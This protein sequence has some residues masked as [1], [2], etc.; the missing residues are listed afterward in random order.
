MT[1]ETA[2]RVGMAAGHLFTRGDHRH[3]AVIGKDTRLSGYLLEPALTAGL[4]ATGMDIIL[5]G[6]IPTPAVAMLTRSLRADLGLMISASHNPFQ[7]NGIKLFGPDGYKLSPETEARIEELVGSDLSDTLSSP[8]DLGRARRL[9]DASGRYIEF[10]KS[11]FPKGLRLDGLK[12]VVDCAHGA[13]YRVAPAT[14]WELGAEVMTCGDTPDGFNINQQCGS[15][16]PEVMCKKVRESGADIGISLDGDAD[17]VVVADEK[18]VL[19]H[20]D[21]LMATIVG[22]WLEAGRLRGGVV[23]TIMTNLGFEHYLEKLG[24]GLVRTAVGDRHVVS[25]MRELDFNVGG[26][27]SGHVV[28]G[29]HTTTGDGLIAALQML[30]VMVES[31]RPLSQIGRSFEPLPQTLR[32]VRVNGHLELEDRRIDTAVSSG[33]GRLGER[34]R[35][36]VRPS[37]TEQVVRVMVEGEDSALVASIAEDIVESLVH[38]GAGTL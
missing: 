19:L 18:G 22:S 12:I 38:S 7:D 37:G 29:D 4:I 36:V 1:A 11:T 31:Q 14:F 24:I 17:R 9:E 32:N 26:E 6:P 10:V 23:G 27:P 5:A 13:G 28:L 21:Q 2:L 34:G 3:S 15:T 25:R 30:S 33:K 16:S 20:G 35:I 8:S